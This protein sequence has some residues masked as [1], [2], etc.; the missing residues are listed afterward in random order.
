MIGGPLIATEHVRCHTNA[1]KNTS[2][3]PYTILVLEV[4]EKQIKKK[5]KEW[6]L[7]FVMWA[8]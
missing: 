6:Q 4:I 5:M 8:D 1:E 3:V 7:L 2:Y